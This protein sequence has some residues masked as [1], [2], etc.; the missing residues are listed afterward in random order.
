[1]ENPEE[2]RRSWALQTNW[3]T[4]PKTVNKLQ[5][6]P[7]GRIV[8]PF[9]QTWREQQQPTLD[10]SA[11]N[12]SVFIPEGIRCISAAYLHIKLPAAE[13]RAYPGLNIIDTFRLRS[14]GQIVY[15]CDFNQYLADYC[16][17]LTDQK[18]RAFA[19]IY[20]GGD[21]ET[22]HGAPSAREVKL[23]LL[24]PNST[25]MRRSDASTAGHG[26]FGCYVGN[27]KI[28]MEVTLKSALHCG[29]LAGQNDPT[30]IAGQCSI[31]FHCVDV[32]NALR[33]KYEDLRGF[34]NVVVRRFTQLSSGWKA[35]SAPNV[36][37]TDSLSQPSGTVTEIMLLAVPH[38]PTDDH[39]RRTHDYIK[40][41]Y[42]EVIHDMVSQKRLD[43]ES[44]V[45]TELFTN[46][47][48]PP[49]DF[50]SPGRLCFASHCAT[51]STQLW[52]GGYDM[53]NATTLQFRFRFKQVC[54]YRLVAVQYANCKIDGS[55][56]LTSTL[57]G[58]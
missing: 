45:K 54:D 33:R 23:P 29:R 13:Y 7:F 56:I 38:Q 16:E 36:I 31:M 24:L 19:D 27:Q 55:G 30:S 48:V 35:Y 42:F 2:I 10:F 40:P 37:V 18:L 15:E 52:T 26:V 3:Q 22:A 50:A 49:I 12:F 47:F 25:Y 44:K 11:Q 43:T 4:G 5:P 17:S 57:D 32:P 14:G 41:D 9:V 34:F 39:A 21:Q 8:T 6:P 51:D 58:L 46:G 20:M 28:E 1:M 53:S